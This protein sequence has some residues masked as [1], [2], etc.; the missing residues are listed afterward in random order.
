MKRLSIFLIIALLLF[1][2]V[3]AFS[4]GNL[5]LATTTSTEATGLLDYILPAFEKANNVRIQVIAV[6]TGKALR[7]AMDGEAD[8]VLVHAPDLEKKFVDDGYGTDR[9]EF[10]YNDFIIVGPQSDPAGIKGKSVV[11]A[12]RLIA[13]SK[14]AFISRGD[15]SGTDVKEKAIWKAAGTEMPRKKYFEVGQGMGATLTI[16]NEK[17]AY[18][19]SDR[20]TYLVM[21]DK[22]DLAILVEGDRDLFNQYSVIVANPQKVKGVNFDMAKKFEEWITS[23]PVLTKIANFKKGGQKLFFP[24]SK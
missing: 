18:T 8:V 2:S 9:K 24:N 22:I 10:M 17:N 1:V 21:K 5:R 7:L 3:S 19:I 23:K 14:E 4:K 6:G 15:N 20:G 12:F 13:K 11:D 16:A